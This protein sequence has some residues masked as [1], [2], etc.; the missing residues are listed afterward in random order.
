MKPNPYRQDSLETTPSVR[1]RGLS[2]AAIARGVGI[3]IILFSLIRLVLHGHLSLSFVA[4]GIVLLAIPS[5]RALFFPTSESEMR[6][7][8]E[9]KLAAGRGEP[10]E[11]ESPDEFLRDLGRR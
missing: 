5:V 10:V 6:R 4:L 2:A 9:R 8:I 1:R 11:D 3:A 7:E